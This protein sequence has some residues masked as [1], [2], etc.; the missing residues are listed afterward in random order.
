MNV[1]AS[2]P[3]VCATRGGIRT[4]DQRAASPVFRIAT[5]CASLHG[6]FRLRPLCLP[7]WI[8]SHRQ[9]MPA[10]RARTPASSSFVRRAVSLQPRQQRGGVLRI[11]R[12]DAVGQ[13]VG[14]GLE[15]PVGVLKDENE[16]MAA[17]HRWECIAQFPR[18]CLCESRISRG[19]DRAPAL[20]KKDVARAGV[21]ADM[22]NGRPPSRVPFSLLPSAVF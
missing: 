6:D 18:D 22:R 1:L 12:A 5:I 4:N 21:D 11:L 10:R 13:C 2:A 3:P 14:D 8:D 20:H 16:A 7:A 17:F 9:R 15:A 19:M